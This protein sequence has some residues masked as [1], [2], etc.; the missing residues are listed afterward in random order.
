[1]VR[2]GVMSIRLWRIRRMFDALHTIRM[3][4]QTIVCRDFKIWIVIGISSWGIRADQDHPTCNLKSDHFRFLLEFLW[5]SYI[6]KK[7]SDRLDPKF[8]LT[9]SGVLEGEVLVLK[10]VAVDRLAPGAVARREVATLEKTYFRQICNLLFRLLCKYVSFGVIVFLETKHQEA[11]QQSATA[12]V[13]RNDEGRWRKQQSLFLP[14]CQEWSSSPGTWSWGSPCGRRSPWTRSPS[15]RCRGRGSSPT[16]WAPRRHAAG[17]GY[18]KIQFLKVY[19]N[20]II[21]ISEGPF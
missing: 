10:L 8:R 16:S 2:H 20:F 13:F 12:S 18:F 6:K 14:P 19:F 4:S 1:M 21:N 11:G 5:E 15:R 7:S 3:I 17:T 9:R